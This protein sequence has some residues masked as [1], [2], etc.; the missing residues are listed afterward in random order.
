MAPKGKRA[1][2]YW[3]GTVRYAPQEETAITVSRENGA[4]GA[5]VHTCT[6]GS[7][8]KRYLRVFLS[9]IQRE[10]REKL[11]DSRLMTAAPT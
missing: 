1:V 7:W 10:A 9:K 5:S 8:I 2:I 3:S 4:A 11:P 6:L